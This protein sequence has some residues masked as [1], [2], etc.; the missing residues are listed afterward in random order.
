MYKDLQLGIIEELLSEN[1]FILL[2]KQ[3]S[4]ILKN[5]S[6]IIMTFIL[7]KLFGNYTQTN[8]DLDV[9]IGEIYEV[10]L[11]FSEINTGSE[12]IQFAPDEDG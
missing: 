8:G 12:W 3:S 5:S 10:S 6:P 7:Q 2:R 4:T 9:Y 1:I 11:E